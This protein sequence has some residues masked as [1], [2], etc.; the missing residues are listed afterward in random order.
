MT[1]EAD[2]C[3]V[4][5]SRPL[6]FSEHDVNDDIELND[7][8]DNPYE[9]APGDLVWLD[10]STRVHAIEAARDGQDGP[11]YK[12][13]RLDEWFHESRVK[14]LDLSKGEGPVTMKITLEGKEPLTDAE[15]EAK[16]RE[17]LDAV[18][19]IIAASGGDPESVKLV[20]V[21]QVDD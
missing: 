4:G 9:Y 10:E 15:L 1:P 19:G 8:E 20:A 7:P 11:E 6:L 2:S 5:A 16:G 3:T 12:V 21:D 14:P 17:L 13:A 18:R